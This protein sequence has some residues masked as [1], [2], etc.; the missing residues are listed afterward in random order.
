MT[1]VAKARGWIVRLT[2]C[3]SATGATIVACY[4]EVP[5]PQGPLPTLRRE[6]APMGPNPGPIVP[7]PIIPGPRLGDAG[8]PIQQVQREAVPIQRVIVQP[9][10]PSVESPTGP[11][12]AGVP[13]DST[14]DLPLEIPD[15]DIQIVVDAGQPVR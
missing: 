10:T 11:V 2:L 5:G 13:I 6:V 15:A 7:G 3:A 14:A 4:N 1:V 8:V 12:D 9:E